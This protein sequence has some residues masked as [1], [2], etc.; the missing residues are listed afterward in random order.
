MS[1]IRPA[2]LPAQSRIG[3]CAPSSRITPEKFEAA[4]ALLQEQGHALFVHPQCHETYG[5]IAGTAD[6]RAAA[7][8]D[9]LLDDNLDAVFF[10]CGGHRAAEI[11]PLLDWRKI[12]A[13]NPK[14]VMGFS[15]GSV[16]LNAITTKLG[17]VTVFGPTVQYLATLGLSG[18]A[19]LEGAQLH[20]AVDYNGPETQGHIVA[21]TLSLL[22]LL[23]D[24]GNLP[25]LKNAIL[26]VEDCYEELSAIDRLFLLLKQRHVFDNIKALVCGS[27]SNMTDTGRPFGFT[28]EEIVRH[29][30][31]DV[32]VAFGAPFGH[33]GPFSPLPIGV[34]ARLSNGVLQLVDQPFI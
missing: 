10:A 30:A 7:L 23:L 14:I 15:D 12:S 25:P 6:K 31:G 32:P 3:I 27:F 13:A 17:W 16:L 26:C 29:H 9:L 21:S 4:I 18:F 2:R 1:L 11:L 19:L 22:P 33:A 5:Q 8:Q 34:Q 24:S 28:I 20:Y